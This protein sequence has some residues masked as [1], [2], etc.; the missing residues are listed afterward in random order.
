MESSNSFEFKV[1]IERRVMSVLLPSLSLKRF[2]RKHLS[3]LLVIKEKIFT[4]QNNVCPF[5]CLVDAASKFQIN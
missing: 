2:V 4:Y 5:D 1:N 3:K